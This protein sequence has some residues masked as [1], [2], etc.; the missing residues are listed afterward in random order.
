VTLFL[1]YPGLHGD[2]D[3]LDDFR[4]TDFREADFREADFRADDFRADDFRA[5][6][7]RADDFRADDF[8]AANTN[9]PTRPDLETHFC[10]S[11]FN[12]YPD[13]HLTIIYIKV[14][15]NFVFYSFKRIKH[16]CQ[17]QMVIKKTLSVS[18]YMN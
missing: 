7:F 12:I 9:L 13:L 4:V 10:V 8:R 17:K 18:L 3:G 6:D 2:R 16:V 1:I 5:D 15:K 11:G 14:K